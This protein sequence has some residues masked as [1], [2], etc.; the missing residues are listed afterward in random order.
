MRIITIVAITGIFMFNLLSV[1]G[2]EVMN[3]DDLIVSSSE[4]VT[5]HERIEYDNVSV[6]SGGEI[7]VKYESGRLELLSGVIELDNGGKITAIRTVGEVGQLNQPVPTNHGGNGAGYGGKG[8]APTIEEQ[9]KTYGN[10]DQPNIMRG[11]HGGP[12]AGDVR[13]GEHGGG[14]ITL[15]GDTIIIDGTI[16]CNGTAGMAWNYDNCN[17]PPWD[18]NH[19]LCYYGGGGGSG[20]GILILATNLTIGPN[21]KITANGGDGGLGW[22][23]NFSGYPGS[24]GRI[25]IFYQTGSIDESAVIEAQPGVAPEGGSD[26]GAEAGTVHIQKVNSIAQLLNPGDINGDGTTDSQDL[27]LL[28]QSWHDD[29]E[30]ATE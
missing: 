9:G 28:M 19:T 1:Y 22:A 14:A 20:G 29:I 13:L 21:A 16:D 6:E 23:P 8:G 4:N 18:P 12:G 7:K 17:I 11:A 24:G 26:G 27:F 3:K 10:P 5:L 2:S 15:R 25:K 30:N